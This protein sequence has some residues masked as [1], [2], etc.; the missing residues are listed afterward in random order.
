VRAALPKSRKFS[1][2]EIA[3]LKLEYVDTLAPA[4]Q[5]AA[6][7]LT[8]ERKLSDRV[9]ATYELTPEEVAMMWRTAPPRMPLDPKQEL[10]RLGFT[11]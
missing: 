2:A 1:S 8:L 4:R 11:D 3:R 5:A 9:N 6:E 7:V 10:R